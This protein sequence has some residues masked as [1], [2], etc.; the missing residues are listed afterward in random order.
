MKIQ[1][2]FRSHFLKNMLGLLLNQP[3]QLKLVLVLPEL[4]YCNLSNFYFR[5]YNSLLIMK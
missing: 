5:L 3:G 4:Q 1:G 2:W